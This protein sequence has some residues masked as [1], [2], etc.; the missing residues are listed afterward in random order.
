MP[1]T[2]GCPCGKTLKV[3]DDLAGKRV[4]CAACGGVQAVPA[5]VEEVEVEEVDEVDERDADEEDRPRPRRKK[6]KKPRRKT[7][8]EIDDEI[9]DERDRK[10]KWRAVAYFVCGAVIL[11]GGIVLLVMVQGP[12]ME[13]KDRV[14]GIVPIAIG[15]MA[16][17]KGLV[18]YFADIGEE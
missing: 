15:V 1:I 2:L 14:M 17:L 7:R 10:R 13:I 12:S 11:A 16:M 18:S 8:E 4:K 5:P 9:A 3:A 6:K